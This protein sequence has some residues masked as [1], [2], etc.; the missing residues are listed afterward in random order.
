MVRRW[1]F[2]LLFL[3]QLTGCLAYAYP[4]LV[5]TP[6]QPVDNDDGGAHAFRI[7]VDTTAHQGKPST[8]EFTLMRIPLERFGTV[9]SQLELAPASGIYDPFGIGGMPDHERHLYTMVVRLYKPGHQTKEIR[10]WD[11][12]RSPKWAPAPDLASQEQALDDL[13][14]VPGTDGK[15]T[16]WDAKDKPSFLP[17]TVSKAQFDSLMF[18]SSEYQ[19]LANWSPA[20][21][22]GM[23]AVKA[24]LQQKAIYLRNFAEPPPTVLMK[25]RVA[26][27]GI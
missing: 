22:V 9:P 12:A 16:W 7:D 27:P 4:D 20:N 1:I 10:A 19:R 21:A 23:E 15:T 17:G 5:Y 3:P 11:K 25:D 14:A 26:G 2:A 8:V 18:M 13:L 24:R 6:Q